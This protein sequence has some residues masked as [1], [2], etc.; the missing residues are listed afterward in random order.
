MKQ[1]KIGTMTLHEARKVKQVWDDIESA[2]PDISTERLIEMTRMKLGDDDN[3][4]VTDAL[5]FLHD[6]KQKNAVG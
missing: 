3:C 2:Y 1:Y 6:H 4:R 5:S